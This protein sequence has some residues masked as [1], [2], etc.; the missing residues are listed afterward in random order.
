MTRTAPSSPPGEAATQLARRAA[1]RVRD[2]LASHPTE[3]ELKIRGELGGDDALT[4]P[5]EAAVLFA[6]VLG[7]L[8]EGKAVQVM[9][10]T[11]RLTT[12]QAADFLNVSRPYLIK[13]LESGSI[14]FEKVGTH[15]R[16]AFGDLL[17][18]KARD[19]QQRREAADELSRL[20]QELDAS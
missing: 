12:Q 20:S 4:V 6:Q 3:Q 17:D 15:R 5:R 16:I 1:R 19:H 9:P 7:Y 2:Y 10:A 13:L 18:Y 8:A 14:P 11:S